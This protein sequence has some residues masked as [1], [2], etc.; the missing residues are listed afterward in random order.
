MLTHALTQ[1]LT[2]SMT[3]P[4]TG[5][6]LGVF[7]ILELPQ[8]DLTRKII[9]GLWEDTRTDEILLADHEGLIKTIP[10]GELPYQDGRVN[11]NLWP[12]SDSSDTPT[13]QV[14]TVISGHE[15]QLAIGSGSGAG[16]TAICSG[17]FTGTLTGDASNRISWVSGNPK[18]ASTT[19][20]TVTISGDVAEIYLED[21]TGQAN[22]NPSEYLVADGSS[23]GFATYVTAN[24]NTVDGSGVVTEAVGSVLSPVPTLV[25]YPASTNLIPQSANWSTWWA[26]IDAVVTNDAVAPN[27]YLEADKITELSAV[28][29]MCRAYITDTVSV[30]DSYTFSLWVKLTGAGEGDGT[31]D[32]I[33]VRADAGT[34]ETTSIT[35]TATSAW[36]RVEVPHTFIYVHTAIA[37]HITTRAGGVTELHVW[38]AQ[39]EKLAFSTPIIPTAGATASR[40]TVGIR[41]PFAGYFNQAAYTVV[42]DHTWSVA[43][44]DLSATDMGMV[45]VQEN[46]TSV[47]FADSAGFKSADGTNTPLVDPTFIADN[48]WRCVV[49]GAAGG[50][51]QVSEK[52]IDG[53]GT[54]VHGS[55]LSYDGVFTEGSGW[56][57][58]CYGNVY[59]V[60]IQ[61]L[62]IYDINMTTE[63][64]EELPASDIQFLLPSGATFELPDGSTFIFPG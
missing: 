26:Q 15:Y 8:A 13:T 5:F 7:P 19:S 39:F 6:G 53:V 27:G 1:P 31:F 44:T 61:H 35:I 34:Y 17:A 30:N 63:Q 36:Q 62:S 2:G 21:V 24:A 25:H 64:I 58:L 16:A 10:G 43:Q 48:K 18:T 59:P 33:I 4:L 23:S 52:D 32:L 11:Q 37:G 14:I 55:A 9:S 45:A 57:N 3:Q 50:D 56:I 46:A 47:M 51:F 38:G 40:D 12:T 49:H 20:L 22:Q 42:F 28:Q 54:W 60:V 29:N 41:H